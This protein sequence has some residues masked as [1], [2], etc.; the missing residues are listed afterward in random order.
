MTCASETEFRQCKVCLYNIHFLVFLDYKSYKNQH[1]QERQELSLLFCACSRLQ[2]FRNKLE[3][4]RK[5]LQHQILLQGLR[6]TKV[7]LFLAEF[8]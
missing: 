4:Y 6:D 8:E 1:I 2:V 7:E 5:F 3:S